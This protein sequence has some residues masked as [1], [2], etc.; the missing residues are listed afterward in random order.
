[1]YLVNEDNR[2]LV[3]EALFLQ[4]AFPSHL[5]ETLSRI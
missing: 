5:L 4:K 2:M 1:M 3:K